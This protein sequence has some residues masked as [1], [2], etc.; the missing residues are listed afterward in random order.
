MAGRPREGVTQ[1][2]ESPPPSRRSSHRPTFPSSAGVYETSP[3]EEMRTSY[4]TPAMVAVVTVSPEHVDTPPVVAEDVL[5][6]E[7]EPLF[8]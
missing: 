6:S 2:P 7:L 4:V 1:D 3:S 5:E 8:F